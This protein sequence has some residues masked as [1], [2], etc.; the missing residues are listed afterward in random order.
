MLLMQ[1]QLDMTGKRENYLLYNGWQQFCR[2]AFLPAGFVGQTGIFGEYRFDG[3]AVCSNIEKDI[4]NRVTRQINN[5]TNTSDADITV[6]HLNS[7]Y[8]GDI[9]RGYT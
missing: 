2:F 3:Y 9:A 5:I 7:V 4:D 1:E 6:N 8:V